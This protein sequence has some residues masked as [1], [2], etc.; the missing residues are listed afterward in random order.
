M[1]LHHSL[2]QLKIFSFS[3]MSR[4]FQDPWLPDMTGC[5]KLQIAHLGIDFVSLFRIPTNLEEE[6]PFPRNLKKL[7]L[8]GSIANYPMQKIES[9]MK[10]W[11]CK[12]DLDPELFRCTYPKCMQVKEQ[13]GLFLP[14]RGHT[15]YWSWTDSSLNIVM[16][17]INIFHI[18]HVINKISSCE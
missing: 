10:T 18:S 4:Y 13:F 2:P 15:I 12:L 16:T 5:E 11:D 1:Q 6:G 9:T 17:K 7:F 14:A 8:H 3:I